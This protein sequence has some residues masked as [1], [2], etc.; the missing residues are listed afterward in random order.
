MNPVFL[1]RAGTVALVLVFLTSCN[2]PGPYHPEPQCA[3]DELVPPVLIAPA[4]GS[5][6]PFIP[7]GLPGFAAVTFTWSY[8]EPGCYPYAFSVD[9]STDPG[10]ADLS[11]GFGTLDHRETSRDWQLLP[12]ACYYWRAK[13]YAPD[14]YGP[15]S[16]SWTFCIEGDATPTPLPASAV[17]RGETNCRLGPGPEYDVLTTLTAGETAPIQGQNADGTW[18]QVLSGAGA[19]WVWVEAITVEGS[20]GDWSVLPEPPT[21]TPPAERTYTPEPESGCLVYNDRQE[22]ECVSPCPANALPG[23][24][25]TP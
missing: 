7:A 23:G 14:S 10:F 16:P 19:C 1:R 11:L 4:D 5:L 20:P 6:L 2:L 12:G 13:A 22:L 9:I 21:P 24:A 15:P 25:C 17:S 3:V 8:P 18:L